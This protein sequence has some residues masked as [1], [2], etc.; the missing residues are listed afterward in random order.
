[1]DPPALVVRSWAG[2]ELARP[3]VENGASRGARHW[4]V[5]G[6]SKIS[7]AK[8]GA[9]GLA[10]L[11]LSRPSLLAALWDSRLTQG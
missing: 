2:S 10:A 6:F 7:L 3:L 11:M 9:R 5:A 8:H 1:M 4:G